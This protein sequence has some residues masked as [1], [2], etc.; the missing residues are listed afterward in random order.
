M[1]KGKTMKIRDYA[2][3]VGFDVVGKLTYMGKWDLS[4]RCYSDDGKNLFL[5]DELG[6]IR[7]RPKQKKPTES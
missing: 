4:T 6:M 7:I 3:S 1:E 2:K 5:V